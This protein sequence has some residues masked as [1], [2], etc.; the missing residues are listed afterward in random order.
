[1][2]SWMNTKK[3]DFMP[4]MEYYS[5]MLKKYGIDV[6]YESQENGS[7]SYKNFQKLKEAT[8]VF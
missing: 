5:A 2:K 1:M 7:N 8:F 6:R 3:R 4:L